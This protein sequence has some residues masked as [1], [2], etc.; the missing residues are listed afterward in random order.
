MLLNIFIGIMGILVGFFIGYSIIRSKWLKAEIRLE[1]QQKHFDM[2]K[3][4]LEKQFDQRTQLMKE[5]FQTLSTEILERKSGNLQSANKEQLDNILNPLKEK[6]VNFEKSLQDNRMEDAKYKASFEKVIEE[7]MKQTQALGKD[8][9]N[10]ARALKGDNKMQGD[11]G[12]MVLDELLRESGLQEGIHYEVQS[13]ITD[14]DGRTIRNEDNKMMR[15]DV[16]VHYPDGKDV[17]VDSKVSLVAYIDYVNAESDA[18]RQDAL[19]RHLKSVKSHVDEL[20]S[21]NYA[22]YLK[23]QSREA[24]DFV[25]MFIPNESPHQL[26]LI[27][28]PKLFRYAKDKK[29]LIVSPVNLM[30]LLQVIHIGW[31]RAD[32]EKNQLL[33]LEMAGQ[34]LERLYTFY[35]QFDEVGKELEDAV[36]SYNNSV[37]KLKDGSQSIVKKAEQLKLLGVKM[38][39]DKNLPKRF[40]LEE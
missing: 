1:E 7:M 33:I 3:V 25:V 14:E 12:E 13:S 8:A 34:L 37:L 36:K 19:Q 9:N 16:V 23:K 38:K 27:Q 6:I 17:I 32:Q 31:T 2:L 39:K 35:E 21:K 18:Q 15:P 5:E 26:A 4:E 40:Q 30:A 20:A 28:D 24:V 22:A 10:L 29:V 11:W